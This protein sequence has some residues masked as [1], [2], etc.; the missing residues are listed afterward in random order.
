MASNS[1]CF[2]KQPFFDDAEIDDANVCGSVGRRHVPESSSPSKTY[3][4]GASWPVPRVISR[5]L[6][7]NEE[8]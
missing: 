4:S 1:V 6:S 3:P 7:P 2:W 8:R 5:Y